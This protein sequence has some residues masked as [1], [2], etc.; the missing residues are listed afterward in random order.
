MREYTMKNIDVFTSKPF[1]GNPAGIIS[2]A[3]GLTEEEMKNIAG[4]VNLSESAFVSVSGSGKSAFRVRYFTQSD[5]LDISGHTTIAACY[6]LLEE[7]R[8]ELENG[9]NRIYFDTNIGDVP[10]DIYF[11]G[12]LEADRHDEELETRTKTD[13][14]KIEGGWLDR[15]MTKQSIKSFRPSD[16]RVEEIAEILEIEPGEIVQ[17]GLPLERIS[18]GLEQFL[19]PVKH[20]ETVLNLKPDLI[21]LSLLNKKHGIQTNDIFSLDTYSSDSITYSRHFA[22]AIGLWEDPGSGNAAICIGTYLHRHGVTTREMMVMDQGKESNNFSR[23]H[24]EI[25]KSGGTLDSGFMGGIAT[26]SITRTI[27]IQENSGSISFA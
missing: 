11:R 23:I 27:N 4:E 12:E 16:I 2:R 10:L 25:E 17:T 26:T 18:T 14:V 5:E 20:K 6:S 9:V 21:K 13:S 15:I 8:I 1:H 7:G 22:P 19:I 24:V 3:D